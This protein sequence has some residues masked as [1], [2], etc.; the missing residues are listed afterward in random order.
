MNAS[1]APCQ[2]TPLRDQGVCFWHSPEHVAEAAEARRLG[3]LRR[4]REG[5]LAGAYELE[6]LA[7]TSDLRRLLEIAAFDG[8]G[9]ESS[10]ARVRALTA[11]VQVGARLLETGELE[12]RLANLEATVE[13][14]Q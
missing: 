12:Q 13:G 5:T 3:G 4:R 2:A 14:R 9:L 11:I 6:S 1:G 10:I 7:S 8:L